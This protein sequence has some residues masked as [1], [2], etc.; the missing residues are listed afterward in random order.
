MLESLKEGRGVYKVVSGGG[1]KMC[2]G[3]LLL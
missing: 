2:L 3:L 1:G